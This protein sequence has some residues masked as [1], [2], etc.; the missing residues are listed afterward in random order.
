MAR[1][2][3]I[4]AILRDNRKRLQLTQIQMAEFLHVTR[5]TYGAYEEGRSCPRLIDII[6]IAR[7]CGHQSLDGFLGIEK[8]DPTNKS[9][10]NDYLRLPEDKKKIVDF[11]LNQ[12]RNK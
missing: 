4:S 7:K 11:I 9:I 2:I 1:A 5:S 12:N 10:E 6:E 3:D 8:M